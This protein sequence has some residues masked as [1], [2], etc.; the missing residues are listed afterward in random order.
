MQLGGYMD[1]KPK[2]FWPFV[3]KHLTPAP[4]HFFSSVVSG[5]PA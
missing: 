2:I 3:V 1:A 4:E 5:L